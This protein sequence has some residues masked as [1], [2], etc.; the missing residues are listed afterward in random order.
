MAYTDKAVRMFYSPEVWEWL[1]I[2]DRKTEI[3]DG[4][5]IIKEMFSE[6]YNPKDPPTGYTIMVKD[7]VGSWDE[8]VLDGRREFV[9]PDPQFLTNAAYNYDYYPNA[10]FG[11][12]CVNC[13]SSADNP[14]STYSALRNILSTPI[15][16][17]IAGLPC[18]QNWPPAHLRHS[19]W[20][21]HYR[22][23][24]FKKLSSLRAQ[25]TSLRKQ[26]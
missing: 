13:H 8:V 21:L 9:P 19:T 6:P 25:A 11:Q 10:G 18:S 12:Y 5:M 22:K 24:F 23:L 17:L 1:H 26:V 15:T 2:F 20:G 4:A 16:Y 3:P 7:K 14:E